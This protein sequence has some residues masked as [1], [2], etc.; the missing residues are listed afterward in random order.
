MPQPTPREAIATWFQQLCQLQV[1]TNN[2]DLQTMPLL[3]FANRTIKKDLPTNTEQE[4]FLT[5]AAAALGS[6]DMN[7]PSNITT[8]STFEG[9]LDHWNP[10]FTPIAVLLQSLADPSLQ[11]VASADF[12]AANAVTAFP[13]GSKG[14]LWTTAIGLLRSDIR[15]DCF[16][17]KFQKTINATVDKAGSEMKDLITQIAQLG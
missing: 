7:D 4:T 11:G 12:M 3:A 2:T 5:S 1:A 10:L 15:A 14:A 9:F 8:Y 6:P 13:G 17:D 16:T